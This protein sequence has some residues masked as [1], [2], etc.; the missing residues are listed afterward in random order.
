MATVPISPYDRIIFSGFGWMKRW[1]TNRVVSW[2]TPNIV[3]ML[4]V[5]TLPLAAAMYHAILSRQTTQAVGWLLAIVAVAATDAFDGSFARMMERTSKFGAAMDPLM[6]KL[7]SITL[8]VYF[9]KLAVASHATGWQTQRYA[10]VMTVA[11]DGLLVLAAIYGFLRKY[12]VKA[13]R[14]G[15]YKFNVQ[16]SAIIVGY[17]C[18]I[19]YFGN[20]RSVSTAVAVTAEMF[21]IAS[22]FAVAS[23][24]GH[25]RMRTPAH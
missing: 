7:F 16:V 20:H 1:K 3:T 14:W 10:F 5:L 24:V 19:A 15:K 17:S 9:W 22:V 8:I 6:D 2:G 25:W 23:L 13:V 21:L 4:R 12:E 11:L 18:M